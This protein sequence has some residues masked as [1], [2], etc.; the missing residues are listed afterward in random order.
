M[1][2]HRH[3]TRQRGNS[4]YL[5][6]LHT[7]PRGRIS[8]GVAT[9]LTTSSAQH[10]AHLPALSQADLHSLPPPSKPKTT[11]HTFSANP[12]PHPYP[13]KSLLSSPNPRRRAPI[14]HHPNNSPTETTRVLEAIDHSPNHR[15]RDGPW[16][17]GSR[18]MIILM[19]MADSRCRR[20]REQRRAWEVMIMEG[21]GL[22]G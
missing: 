20:G 19:E 21:A 3:M 18:C 5:H 4:S 17:R 10:L 7:Q 13:A 11:D 1:V 12:L 15:H 16:R 6:F 22:K 9:H 8:T 2:R 14:G